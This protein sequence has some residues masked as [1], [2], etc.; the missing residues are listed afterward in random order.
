[1]TIAEK[2]AEFIKRD[3]VDFPPVGPCQFQVGDKV[4]FTNEY[5]VS[6]PGKIITGFARESDTFHGRFIHT[7]GEAYWFPSRPDE[8]TLEN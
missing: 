1:M 6:F 4:T 2:E 7:A 3:L 8:L 5:G